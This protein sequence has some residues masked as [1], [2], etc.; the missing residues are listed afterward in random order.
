MISVSGEVTSYEAGKAIS[1]KDSFGM[2]HAM[3]ITQEIKVDGDVKVG[4]KVSVESDGKARPVKA[5]AGG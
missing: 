3:K 4:A 2:V 5:R 1:V